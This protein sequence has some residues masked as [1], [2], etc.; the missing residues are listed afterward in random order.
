[1]KHAKHTAGRREAP[2]RK[3]GRALL[4][5]TV[6]LA[7]I[8]A[9]VLA[10]VLSDGGESG[11]E[12]ALSQ[13]MTTG[14][15]EAAP[16][17]TMTAEE[18]RLAELAGADPVNLP[19]N[20]GSGVYVTAVE[21]A[22]G[23]YVEDGTDDMVDNVLR[24]T[25][26][27]SG[28]DAIQLMDIILT[29]R[30]GGEYTFRVTTLLPG[31]KMTVQEQNRAPFDSGAEYVEAR[32]ENVALFNGEL[33]LHE[34]LLAITTGDYAVAVENISGEAFPGGRVFYKNVVDGVYVGGITYMLTIPELEAG[35]RVELNSLHFLLS[36]SELMF[37]TYAGGE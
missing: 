35:E 37:V 25:V 24:I 27:N 17:E 2:R 13:S 36:R 4:W 26:E 6:A 20:L 19:L 14:E 21:S 16:G 31:A 12:W 1:M 30:T 34:E 10:V 23:L 8:L 32:T 5:V 9:G 3:K 29:D 22:A 18:E 28:T 33:S 15:D 7:L 11:P